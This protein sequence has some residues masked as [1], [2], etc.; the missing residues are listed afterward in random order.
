[1]RLELP[2]RAHQRLGGRPLQECAR[3]RVDRPPRKLCVG[4]VADVEPIVGSSV[5][6]STRSLGRSS[7]RGAGGIAARASCRSSATGRSGSMRKT[8]GDEAHPAKVTAAATRSSLRGKFAFMTPPRRGGS[9][10]RTIPEQ[11]RRQEELTAHTTC[12]ATSLT[13]RSASSRPP[14]C[15]FT[16]RR[17]VL[18][19]RVGSD[20]AGQVTGR[21]RPQPD[22]CS[23]FTNVRSLSRSCPSAQ[24]VVATPVV[25]ADPNDR[26]GDRS[27]HRT[28]IAPCHRRW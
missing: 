1:M 4:R 20:S 19:D 28:V 21:V 7:P 12:T 15:A 8:L 5:T 14:R 13:G 3:L 26:S 9:V 11:P 17:S 27:G 24:P 10:A 16:R 23:P 25:N 18:Y 22:G 6:S 2:M